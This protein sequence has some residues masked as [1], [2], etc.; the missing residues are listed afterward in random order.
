M[1][2]HLAQISM[3]VEL[4]IERAQ[5]HHRRAADEVGDVLRHPAAGAAN[6]L[7]VHRGKLVGLSGRSCEV[8]LGAVAPAAEALRRPGD[9]LHAG[10]RP[11]GRQRQPQQPGPRRRLRDR[12]AAAAPRWPPGCPAPPRPRRSAAPRSRAQRDVL[13]DVRAGAVPAK[14]EQIDAVAVRPDGS[15]QRR[16]AQPD[17]RP[18]QRVVVER[19]PDH[20]RRALPGRAT[21]PRP[22]PAHRSGRRGPR[23]RRA[24][25]RRPPGRRRR[26]RTT[27]TRAA[28]M[29]AWPS[30][31]TSGRA[32]WRA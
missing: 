13:T 24:G 21:R 16:D 3:S 18:Q 26:R 32:I 2:S 5:P 27:T 30:G 20:Q 23:R 4:A 31:P 10:R 1:N 11:A 14:G 19:E 8:G 12:P 15:D 29:R 17:R 28:A 7:L 22:R 25:S 6:R 9:L